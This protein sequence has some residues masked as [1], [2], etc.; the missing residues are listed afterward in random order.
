MRSRESSWSWKCC[1]ANDKERKRVSQSH[2]TVQKGA[3]HHREADSSLNI[4]FKTRLVGG[5]LV[6]L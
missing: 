5:E 3:T 6:R 1:S 4:V 2:G